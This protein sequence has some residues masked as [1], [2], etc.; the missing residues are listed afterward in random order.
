M[1]AKKKAAKAGAAAT[2]AKNSPYV[3]RLIEDED[4]RENIVEAYESARKAYSRLNNGK[5]P[6][7]AIF[8]DKKLQ[9]ELQQAASSLR[10][11]TVAMR[12][13]PKAQRGG[14]FGRKLLLLLVAGGTALA[15]SEGLRKKVLDALFGAEEEFE[16]TSPTTPPAPAPASPASTP[17]A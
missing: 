7:K 5:S 15:L 8:D 9:K 14:G 2:A 16:Y 3:Q 11:A 6:T 4:L 13:A 12:E 10:D 17:S 1:A